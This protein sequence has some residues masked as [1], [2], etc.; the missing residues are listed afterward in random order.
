MKLLVDMNLSPRLVGT[1]ASAG[2][3]VQHWSEVGKVNASDQEILSYAAA[4]DYVVITH[5][6]DFGTSSPSLTEKS[7]ALCKF[8]AWMSVSMLSLLKPLRRY[9]LQRPS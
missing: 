8:V 6:L 9:V 1:L 3:H 4:N 5:D 2:W 7:Q